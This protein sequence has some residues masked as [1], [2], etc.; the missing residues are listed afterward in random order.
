MSRELSEPYGHDENFLA[1]F[2]FTHFI[3]F[4]TFK[5]TQIYCSLK[6]K[7]ELIS[8]NTNFVHFLSLKDG[9]AG[10]Y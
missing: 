6:I 3:K 1:I 7:F 10:F 4:S 8:I 9:V 5:K 2:S